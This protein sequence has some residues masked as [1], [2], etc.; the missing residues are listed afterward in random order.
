MMSKNLIYLDHY[1][2]WCGI[3]AGSMQ[4][5]PQKKVNAWLGIQRHIPGQTKIFHQRFGLSSTEIDFV[6]QCKKPPKKTK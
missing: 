5:A 2:D 1:Q 6:R 4:I 3:E